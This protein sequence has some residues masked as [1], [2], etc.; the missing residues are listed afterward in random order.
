LVLVWGTLI[1]VIGLTRGWGSFMG[2]RF[3]YLPSI[4]VLVLTV[5][6]S[7]N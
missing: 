5:W 4:G 2:D 7:A 1:P 3:T 6:A